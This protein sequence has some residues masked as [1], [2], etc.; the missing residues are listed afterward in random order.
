MPWW[1]PPGA[2]VQ[3]HDVG[4]RI[5]GV[6]AATAG[7]GLASAVYQSCAEARD[8]RRFPPPGRLVDIGGRRLH[9]WL[10][11]EGNP[12]VV[13]VPALGGTSLDWVGVQRALHPDPMVCLVD[14]A[15]LGWS[16]PGRWPRSLGDMADELHR[17]L[18]VAG[19][20]PPYVL[21]GH[22]VGGLIARLYCA[23]HPDHA[24][25]L[26][27]VD[28]SHEDQMQRLGRVDREAGALRYLMRAGRKLAKPLGILRA[29]YDLGI[30]RGLGHD[31]EQGIPPDLA[32][33]A[34]AL[35]LTARYHR[36]SAQEM[37][38]FVCGTAAVRREA[39]TLGELPLTVITAGPR[40]RETWYSQWRELQE[41]LATNL[42]EYATH[43][44]EERSG[45]HVNRDSQDLVV[46]AIRELVT[47]V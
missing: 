20:Q 38:G 31:A 18:E 47:R 4:T 41:D 16:D 7:V 19:V 12:P 37:I 10:V 42:S 46:Q 40:G 36:A 11:G 26:V 5:L 17:A 14:R 9:L 2:V 45:H 39:R 28:S 33:A 30:L 3:D 24:A 34:V 43:L 25:G 22:S 21:V 15:G 32:E 27:L 13:I 6:A 29:G 23:R 8:R 1:R 44:V 35:S